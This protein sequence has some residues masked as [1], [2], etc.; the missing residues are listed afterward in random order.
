MAVP[1][2][3]VRALEL[4]ASRPVAERGR[5]RLVPGWLRLLLSNPKSRGGIVV[6]GTMV[7]VA[8]AAPL[9][10]RQDPQESLGLLGARQPPSFQHWFGTTDQ[11]YDIFSQVVWGARTSLLLGAAAAVLATVLAT[12]LGILAAYAGGVVDDAITF[13]AN[14]FLVIPTIPLLI[15]ISAYLPRR[16][17]RRWC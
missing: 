9:L 13:L 10:A 16:G 5:R 15:V 1:G 14:V 2:T 7:T 8:L 3:D 12:T 6:L 17:R 11:G 4:P